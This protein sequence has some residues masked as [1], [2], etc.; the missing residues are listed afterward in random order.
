MKRVLKVPHF[1]IILGIM[2]CGALLY[3]AD[4]IPWVEDVVTGT[5]LA[6]ARYS[7]HRILS[8]IP[9]AYAAWSSASGAGPLPPRLS[10]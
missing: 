8:I 5:P 10:A 4:Q 1:W 2:T 7:T 3:Y 9:V 6:L